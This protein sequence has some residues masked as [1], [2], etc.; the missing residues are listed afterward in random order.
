[1]LNRSPDRISA[2]APGAETP[3]IERSMRT[4]AMSVS[5][6]TSCGNDPTRGIGRAKEVPVT[7]G[8]PAWTASGLGHH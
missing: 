2:S 3:G 7:P 1:M 5:E 4:L 6:F 8:D